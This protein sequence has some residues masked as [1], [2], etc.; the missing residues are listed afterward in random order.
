[1]TL[2]YQQHKTYNA[3]LYNRKCETNF[4]HKNKSY[5]L[6]LLICNQKQYETYLKLTRQLE[7]LE[8]RYFV[9]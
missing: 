1:M 4:I 9:F 3:Y 8:N 6:K 5:N 7:T 2:Y